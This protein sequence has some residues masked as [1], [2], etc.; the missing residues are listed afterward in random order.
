MDKE[1]YIMSK[2]QEHYDYLV[3]AGYDV[4]CTCL[5]GS[6]NYGLDEYSED[7]MSDVDTKSIVLPTVDSFIDNIKPVSEVIVM[8]DNSHAE[9]KDIRVMFDMFKKENISYIELLFT[10][11]KI[12]N[13]K[14]EKLIQPIFAENQAIAALNKNQF[15]RCIAGMAYEKNKAL[16]HPYP[17]II[18]K[19]EKYG[20]DG[21]QLSH[22]IRLYEF[23][24]RYVAGEPIAACYKSNCRIELMLL[25]K[26]RHPKTGLLL[27]VEEAK[28]L[29]KHYMEAIKEIKDS[30]VAPIDEI[31]TEAIEILDKVKHDILK[32]KLRLDLEEK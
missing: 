24:T 1:K 31:K 26:Q 7:Y 17:G 27:D 13:P 15:L 6:Q 30:A 28:A 32:E 11:Y 16:C 22:C 21:K 25:K 9:V 14:W 12:I 10:D 29:S 23:I 8:E 18:D 2:V 4:V 20:F 19:I 3:V 5:Q